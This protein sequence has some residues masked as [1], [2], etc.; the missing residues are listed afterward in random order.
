[1]IR[2]TGQQIATTET[3]ETATATKTAAE[4]TTAKAQ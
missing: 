4:A 1:M 3:T 2:I